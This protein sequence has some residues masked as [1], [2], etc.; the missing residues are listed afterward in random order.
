[1]SDRSDD[2]TAGRVALLLFVFLL[3][4]HFGQIRPFF[5]T[6][7]DLSSVT[8]LTTWTAGLPAQYR[9]LMPLLVNAVQGLAGALGIAVSFDV[10]GRAIDTLGLLGF[11]LAFLA[12][13]RCYTHDIFALW[14]ASLALYYALL[15]NYVVAPHYNHR[16]MYDM[17]ALALFTTAL[18]AIKAGHLRLYYVAFVLGV[19]NR[20]TMIFATVAFLSVHFGEMDGRR[21]LRH[22]AAQA[23]FYVAAKAVLYWIFRDHPAIGLIA[24]TEQGLLV[25]DVLGNL[26]DIFSIKGVIILA[27]A[28]GGLWLPALLFAARTRDR[29][30]RRLMVVVPVFL[31]AILLAG[32]VTELRVY[33]EL[34]PIV[35]L[36][37]GWKIAA[38]LNKPA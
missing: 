24:S 4:V 7:A 28:F 35:A 12:L 3:S 11:F 1:M 38:R 17:P 20:E 30:L 34:V 31:A 16:C 8:Q 22:G 10:A 21:L 15:V 14:L 27:P 5:T 6:E 29:Y 33:N 25:D 9:V 36:L 26:R 13:M 23:A 2:S 19:L 18:Y 37:V 32:N